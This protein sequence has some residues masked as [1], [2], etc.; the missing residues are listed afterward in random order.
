VKTKKGS[1]RKEFLWLQNS[2]VCE[3][4]V[5]AV[6]F[7]TTVERK[8]LTAVKFGREEHASSVKGPFLAVT[9]LFI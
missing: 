6:T 4:R 3:D 2:N 9:V 8:E 7:F 1:D 5:I